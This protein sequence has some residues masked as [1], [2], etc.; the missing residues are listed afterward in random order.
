MEFIKNLARAVGD[1]ATVLGEKHRRTA[2]RNRIR[3]VLRCEERAAQ[4]EY[5]ALG[6]YYYNTLRDK[7]NPVAEPHCEALDDIELRIDAALALMQAAAAEY[8][9]E[10]D[11][12]DVEYYDE[13]P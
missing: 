3:A 8:R 6:R 10:I 11:L 13:E 2:E 1:A 12:A 7:S 5:L 4:K 9:E